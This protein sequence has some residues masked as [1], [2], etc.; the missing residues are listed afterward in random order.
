MAD[1]LHQSKIMSWKTISR[2]SRLDYRKGTK[3]ETLDRGKR[4]Q[5]QQHLI[6][7]KQAAPA[8]SVSCKEIMHR[9]IEIRLKNC[10]NFNTHRDDGSREG[11]FDV[12]AQL[13]PG[14]DP[15]PNICRTTATTISTR[16]A[17][18]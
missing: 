18:V 1:T 17:A 14:I 2:I 4:Q 9:V 16:S 11:T 5:G 8:A 10:R 7:K 3:I 13:D 12:A 15:V 6:R